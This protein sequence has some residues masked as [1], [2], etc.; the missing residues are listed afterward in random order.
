MAHHVE[1]SKSSLGDD[2]DVIQKN[3]TNDYQQ[4][5]TLLLNDPDGAQ[6]EKK[7]PKSVGATTSVI[8]T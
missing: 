5:G 1:G 7:T 6:M 8:T 4:F 3:T 2:I